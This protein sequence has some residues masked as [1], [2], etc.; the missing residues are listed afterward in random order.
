MSES[1][2]EIQRQELALMFG[3]FAKLR[4]VMAPL[5]ISLLAYILISDGAWWRRGVILFVVAV[6]PFIV[7]GELWRYNKIGLRKIRYRRSFVI[8]SLGHLGLCF[9]TGGIESPF[10]A[11]IIPLS[12]M[13]GVLFT[14]PL[15]RVFFPSMYVAS[16]WLMTLAAIR[17]WIPDLVPKLFGGGAR[18][19]HSDGLLLV[20]ATAYSLILI[21]L[22]TLTRTL[23]TRFDTLVLRA[24]QARVDALQ[25]H[26]DQAQ[27]LTSLSA[28]IAHE[29]KNPLASVKGLAALMA[30]EQEGKNV[31]RVAVLRREIERMQTILDEFLNFSRPLGPLTRE[32]VDLV[33]LS[34]A[35]A[36][37]HEGMCREAGVTVDVRSPG[38]VSVPCDSRK[39]KQILINLL[40]NAIE[41]S[42]PRSRIEIEVGEGGRIRVL[43]RGAG[44]PASMSGRVFEAG[45]TTKPKGNGL[46]LT[47][48][49]ALARQHG[50][51]VSLADRPGGGC[52]A[53]VRLPA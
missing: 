32:A 33:E 11:G 6:M 24:S 15:E 34:R 8:M 5:V 31:E 17:G 35:V 28:E 40:Q 3:G 22:F 39:V 53:E 26:A 36:D 49:R 29:L 19:G 51:E 46:G 10:I 20:Q 38:V 44:L 18:A 9:A 45:A 21:G 7:A 1:I 13:L 30:A 25:A 37:L 4:A 42:P 16:A 48:A 2:E 14:R 47:V 43:D 27:L 52:L 23:R 41:A 50:G 12:L